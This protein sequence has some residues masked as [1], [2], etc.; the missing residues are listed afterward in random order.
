VLVDFYFRLHTALVIN[1]M[2]VFSRNRIWK[3]TAFPLLQLLL[4]L[5]WDLLAY[6]TNHPVRW[7]SILQIPRLP[8]IF[9]SDRI[10]VC[11]PQSAAS[12]SRDVCNVAFVTIGILHFVACCWMGIGLA[13]NADQKV[14]VDSVVYLHHASVLDIYVTSFYFSLSTVFGIGMGE[15]HPANNIERLVAA[16]IL[17][18]GV[19]VRAAVLSSFAVLMQVNLH[20]ANLSFWISAR[21]DFKSALKSASR[22]RR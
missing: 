3:E 1:H 17:I 5:P 14:W 15:I 8:L 7:L 16:G 6:T 2:L 13:Y 19:V 12:T 20:S 22:C 18:I 21:Y 10:S 4:S 11:F 9:V